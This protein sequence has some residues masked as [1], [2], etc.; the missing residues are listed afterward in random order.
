MRLSFFGAAHEVTGSC[1]LLEACGK[2]ILIDC[3]MEQGPDLY[4]NQ[5][6]P[7]APGDVDY[8]LLTHAHIDHSGNIPLL[9]KKGFSGE[10]ITTFATADLCDIMLRDSAHIQEFEAEWRNRKARRSGE[11]EYEPIYTVADADAATKLL[12]PVD[13]GQK[14]TLCDGIEVRFNDV[15]HLLGS[16]SI[17]VWITEGDVSKKVVFSGDVG[18]VNQPIIKD[19]Q[20]VKEADYLV[21]ESTYGDRTHGEDIPDYVGEFTRILRETFQKGG[22]VVI[23]SFAVGRTQEILYFIREIKEKNLLPEFPGFEVYVDS[24]LAIEATN[25]FNKNVKG[26]FDEEAM[27]LVNQGINP[28]LFRGLKTTITSDESRQI[29]FDTKPKVILSASGMC[30]AGRIRHNL[31]HNLWRPECTICFVGYQAV[32]TLGRKLIEGAQSVKLFGENITVNAK[33]EVLRGISGHADMNGLLDWIR[34]FEKIPDRVMVVH[35]EDTVTDHFAKLVEDTFGCPAFA[36]YSGGTVDLAANEIIT[37]GQ[38]IPK[39]S[40]EKPSKLKSASAF[41]R[42]VAAAKRLLN[43]VY[44]NEGLANKDMA[45]FE[46]QIQN[47]AEQSNTASGNIEKIVSALIDNS[48]K[49]VDT[50]TQTQDIISRQNEHIDSTEHTV[51]GVINELETSI[52]KIRSIEQKAKE[53]EQARGEIIEAIDSLSVIAQQ[54]V[55]GTAQT[56][57]AITEM[58]DSFQVIEDSTENLRSTADMLAQNISNFVLPDT[59]N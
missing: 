30:E 18:N 17:E 9:V 55:D 15:G 52:T 25:V 29:N 40:D 37:I 38:K 11:P 46:T 6:L 10:I 26:C 35:G 56:S 53:L 19:P 49:V 7:V 12:A 16:A 8:I 58:A 47:L 4:E 23:P 42:L 54:N 51:N 22:N 33:I 3:G 50:M 32:G 20:L 36:P 21:I 44:K 31:K 48:E 28:L 34:G 1:H 14:I 13:Y 45:K 24:P 27:E 2:N 57:A 43:V 59:E 5:E 41:N 39:K